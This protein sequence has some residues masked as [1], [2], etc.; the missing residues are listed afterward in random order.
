MNSEK[1]QPVR[2]IIA[3]ALAAA[4]V[5]LSPGPQCYAAL[6]S[7]LPARSRR[8]SPVKAVAV[9]AASVVRVP[10]LS[11]SVLP[12]SLGARPGLGAQALV[13][14]E[15]AAAPLELG[16]AAPRPAQAAAASAAGGL[17]AQTDLERGA[18]E[19]SQ[20]RGEAGRRASLDR[21]FGESKIYLAREGKAPVEA[22]LAELDGLLDRDPSIREDINRLG[23]I[24]L[25]LS[26][27][28]VPG[29]LTEADAARLQQVFNS[30]GI[31]TKLQLENIPINWA[32][33]D[34]QGRSLPGE[35]ASQSQ[36]WT[37]GWVWTYL[38]GPLTAPFREAAYLAKTLWA[39]S[40]LPTKAEVIGGLISKA[41]PTTV[42][43]VT[44]CG[45]NW[46]IGTWLHPQAGVFAGHPV[47]MLFSVGISLGLN[48]FHGIWINTWS[49]FQNLIGKQRGVRYQAVFNFFYNQGWGVV[50]RTIA[51]SA[52]PKTIP[53]WS[54]VYWKDV[55][56]TTIVGTFCGTLGYQGLN[57]L[58][59][60]GLLTRWQRGL[61]QQGR[62]FLMCIAGTFFNTGSMTTFWTMFLAQ[63]ALDLAIYFISQKA[64]RRPILYVADAAVAR[65][66]EFQTLYPVKS[67]GTQDSPLKQAAH[68]L[69]GSP[70]V[71][72]FVLLFKKIGQALKKK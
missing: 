50:F 36:A 65:S 58:Y 32:R 67:A 72:P 20:A 66:G 56:I 5:L 51:W 27:S 7:E 46:T 21:I 68:A 3:S 8:G 9:R 63:Q 43:L 64:A 48:A 53:P 12:V 61:I 4:L 33:K 30:H 15:P 60:K 47:A 25:V 11:A 45:F 42:M 23:R 35:T 49:N 14:S 69:L 40:S 38:L 37:N 54:P 19:L 59:D 26:K 18:Q 16:A 22:T 1:A 39:A 28:K 24:R 71:K 41:V 31:T 55:G 34:G 17:S 10:E 29:S 44:Y 13:P 57:A 52:I 70:F 62:D 6:S 2:A